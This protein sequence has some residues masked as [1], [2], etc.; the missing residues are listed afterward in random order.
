[1]TDDDLKHIFYDG[2]HKR[3]IDALRSIASAARADGAAE[4]RREI[5]ALFDDPEIRRS[6]TFGPAHLAMTLRRAIRSRAAVQS[7]AEGEGGGNG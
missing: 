4:E 6:A 2:A 1:M 5:D 7:A 3:M